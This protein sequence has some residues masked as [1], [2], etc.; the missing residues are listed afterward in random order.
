MIWAGG[1]SDFAHRKRIICEVPVCLVIYWGCGT[2][3][4]LT[5]DRDTTIIH[6]QAGLTITPPLPNGDTVSP[7]LLLS[8]NGVP[9]ALVQ[10]RGLGYGFRGAGDTR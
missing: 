1:T 5:Q 7:G 8:H 2:H 9:T 6:L 4:L 3:T 10:V